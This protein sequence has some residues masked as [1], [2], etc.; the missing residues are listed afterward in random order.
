M[1]YGFGDNF[2]KEEDIKLKV[3]EESAVYMND[4]Q[5]KTRIKETQKAMEKAAKSLDFMEAA[6]YRDEIKR[7][8]GMVNV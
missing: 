2:T 3:A 8:K 7:L 5:L 1:N 4:T 6:K